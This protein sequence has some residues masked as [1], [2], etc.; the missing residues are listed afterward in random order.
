MGLCP[1]QKIVVNTGSFARSIINA[2]GRI[3]SV[4]T[5]GE[6]RRSSREPRTL[7]AAHVHTLAVPE[8]ADEELPSTDV[9]LH[10]IE[11]SNDAILIVRADG[12]IRQVNGATEELFGYSRKE[13]TGQRVEVLI[14]ELLRRSHMQYRQTYIDAP[15]TRPM[16]SSHELYAVRRD[17]AVLPVDISLTP[18]GSGPQLSG[19]IAIVRDATRRRAAD[20]ALRERDQLADDLAHARKLEALGRLAVE[21][22]H[23]FHNVLT[24]IRGNAD[25]L[26]AIE[27]G[28]DPRRQMLEDIQ[29]AV[30]RGATLTQQLLAFG[31]RQVSRTQIVDL[32]RTLTATQGSLR[33]VIGEAIELTLVHCEPLVPVAVDEGQI[34]SVLLNLASNARDAM[35]GGGTLQ[36]ELANL[37]LSHPLRVRSLPVPVPPG[38]YVLLTVDDTGRGMTSTTLKRAFE[39]FFS[40][41]APGRGTGVGLASVY[42]II[43]QSGA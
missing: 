39:P 43:E 23:D 27:T 9:L 33:R 40:T 7:D 13:L 3:V 11:A 12:Q 25:L 10:V 2:V 14:P 37:V 32:N 26:K 28:R 5:S 34:E 22:A 30:E 36:I 6:R 8:T 18:V 24:V 1:F 31:R 29:R 17:G 4:A 41:K 16:S 42:G 20:A 21:V 19:V 38:S 35:P 15:R